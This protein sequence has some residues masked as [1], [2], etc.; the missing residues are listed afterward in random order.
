[1]D[2]AHTPHTL[3]SS[4]LQLL[5]KNIVCT[6]VLCRSYGHLLQFNGVVRIKTLPIVMNFQFVLPVG[7]NLNS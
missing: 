7:P 2:G 1:M 6:L 5:C 4:V 3:L